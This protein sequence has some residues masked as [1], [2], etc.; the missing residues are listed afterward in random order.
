MSCSAANRT[1]NS[2]STSF[3]AALSGSAPTPS[4]TRATSTCPV[5]SRP[6]WAPISPPIR[7]RMR[8][9]VITATI[10]RAA[11]FLFV[12]GSGGRQ[13]PR[14]FA[15]GCDQALLRQPSGGRQHF[16]SFPAQGGAVR[17]RS[18]AAPGLCLVVGIAGALRTPRAG[19]EV[20][21]RPGGLLHVSEGWT[22]ASRKAYPTKHDAPICDHALGGVRRLGSGRRTHGTGDSVLLD[23]PAVYGVGAGGERHRRAAEQGVRIGEPGMG[24]A[25]YAG[26]E[27]PAGVA[28]QTVYGG[29]HPAAPGARE[30]KRARPG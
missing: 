16:C 10:R 6:G 20:P 12:S 22:R 4:A 21:R 14:L 19:L 7:C 25:E 26:D 9:S 18:Y 30:I 23:E 5:T 27:V 29:L 8:S 13:F 3:T 11:T 15:A 1:S 17:A 28:H 2:S 24:C